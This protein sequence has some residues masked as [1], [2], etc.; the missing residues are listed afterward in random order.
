MDH[1]GRVDFVN[2]SAWSE[3][4][5]LIAGRFG[6]KIYPLNDRMKELLVEELGRAEFSESEVQSEFRNNHDRLIEFCTRWYA[7]SGVA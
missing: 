6:L 1:S 4:E 5:E 2:E 3:A 7:G